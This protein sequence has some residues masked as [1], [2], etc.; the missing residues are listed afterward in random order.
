MLT[1]SWNC[2]TTSIVTWVISVLWLSCVI[3]FPKNESLN[4]GP[5]VQLG[6][7]EL[8]CI[9]Q[10][11]QAELW[12]IVQLGQAELWCIVQLGQVELWCIVQLGQAELWCIVQ[13]GQ[14]ELWC[15]VQLGQA[16]LWCIV[17]LGQA[18]L[19]CIVQLGQAELWLY[20][21]SLKKNYIVIMSVSAVRYII[22]DR[23]HQVDC[24]HFFK[25]QFTTIQNTL[26]F[27]PKEA[28]QFAL[29]ELEDLYNELPDF[30]HWSAAGP[31]A[32][33]PIYL[34]SPL[35][36]ASPLL[37]ALPSPLCSPLSGLSSPLSALSSPLCSPL[38]SLLSLSPSPSSLGFIPVE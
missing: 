31:R 21:P 9:V 38:P 6:Q 28:N 1:V 18:E 3:R 27:N 15:I 13:L 8:W 10:L 29:F 11:G 4:S 35:C 20:L 34:A 23:P 36:S 30:L 37:S 14:A 12:C 19:W 33:L 32:P 22:S 16:E 24:H 2:S 17:Q 5:T 25:D 26:L 7:V